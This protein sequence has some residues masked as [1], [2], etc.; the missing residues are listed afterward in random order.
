MPNRVRTIYQTESLHIGPSPGTGQHF[1]QFGAE[2]LFTGSNLITGLYRIQ[3]CNYNFSVNRTPVQQFGELAAIDRVIL[4]TPTVGLSFSYLLANMWNERALGFVTD[5]RLSALSGILNKVVDERNYFLKIVDEGIDA[6]GDTSDDVDVAVVGFGNGFLTSY[7]T[8]AAVNSFPSVDV[9]VSALNMTFSTG[10]S[11]KLPSINPE[12]GQRITNFHYVVPTTLSSPGTGLLDISVLRPGDITMDFKKRETEDEGVLLDAT[13]IYAAPGVNIQ[14]AKIQSYNLS[15]DLGREALQKLGS[16]FA[17][18]REITF[19]VDIS[20][21][22][23]A[24]VGDLTT[25]SLAAIVDDD[26]SY[27]ITINI[28]KPAPPGDPQP[29]MARYVVKSAKLNNQSFSNGIGD[30]KTV[31]LEFAAQIGGPHQHTVGIFMSGVT[32]VQ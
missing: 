12:N 19:P 7:S 1:K 8:S 27:D 10:L 6:V 32:D 3:N 16:R 5:G 22:V 21:T 4:E 26:D 2:S 9:S 13:G 31:S 18:S 17:F 11:G 28:K 14:N 23:D 29:V 15:F 25:G 20:L 30:N 24:L